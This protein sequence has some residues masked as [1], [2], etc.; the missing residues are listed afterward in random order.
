MNTHRRRVWLAIAVMGLAGCAPAAI[1]PAASPPPTLPP[2]G[3]VG[4][5]VAQAVADLS[6]RLN[7][8]AASI[9]VVSQ[10]AVT[11]SDGSLGCP[12]PGVNYIQITIKGYRVVLRHGGKTYEYHAGAQ[13]PSFLCDN[14]AA[15]APS[16]DK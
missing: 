11:W 8:P 15:P 6:A 5:A 9:E 4:T 7:V 2:P 1:E 12:Q 13:R 10:E 14:P 3:D 16:S